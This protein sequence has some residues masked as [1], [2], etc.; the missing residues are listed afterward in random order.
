MT[1]NKLTL[2]RPVTYE[3]II[4]G[5]LNAGWSEWIEGMIVT[6]SCVDSLPITTLRCTV[7][8]AGLLGLLRRLYAFG[9]PLISVDCIDCAPDNESDSR[10]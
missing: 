2:D 3:I 8:Q 1:G 6:F 10:S 4:S 7:D 5:Q 9:L